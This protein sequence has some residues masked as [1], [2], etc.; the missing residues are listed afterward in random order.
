M[1]I[2]R[3]DHFALGVSD[4][5]Q[6]IAHFESVAGLKLI[7]RGTLGRTGGA[8]AMIGD[9]TGMK[10]ELVE[11]PDATTPTLLHIAFRSDDV[12]SDAIAVEGKAGLSLQRGPNPLPAASALSALFSR[13]DGLEVQII[14]Y[15]ADSPD[16][17]EW[18]RAAG[19]DNP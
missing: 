2:G 4:I 6:A 10:I 18:G 16:I 3:I 14:Q 13:P 17:V 12:A 15:E 19:K 8:M 9:G 7:R 11:T 5:E 1:T